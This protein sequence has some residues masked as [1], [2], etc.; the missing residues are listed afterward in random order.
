MGLEAGHVQVGDQVDDPDRPSH[1]GDVLEL[2]AGPL[3]HLQ[4]AL[5]HAAGDE[6][7]AAGLV[8]RQVVQEGEEGGGERLGEGGG[9]RAVGRRQADDAVANHHGQEPV[10]VGGPRDVDDCVELGEVWVPVQ[11][12]D[13]GQGLQGSRL[14]KGRINKL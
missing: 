7:L 1:E 5:H 2:R 12:D 11:V 14:F 4:E 6:G 10:E 13:R 3:D 9:R 8:A